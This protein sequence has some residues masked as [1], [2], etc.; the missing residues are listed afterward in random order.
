MR[1]ESLVISGALA[2]GY[3]IAGL[4]FLRFWSRTRDR[5]FAIFATAFGLLGTQR[6][7]LVVAEQYATDTTW[8]YVLRL[9]A[10]VLILWAII[11]KN[12]AKA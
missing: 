5:L 6:L 2:M 7:A 11:D 9:T 8:I 1:V 10:F 12:R 4:F 3:F